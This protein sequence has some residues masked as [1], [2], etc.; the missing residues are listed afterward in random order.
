MQKPLLLTAIAFALTACGG[1]GSSALSG[2]FTDAEVANVEYE[3]SSGLRG[4]TD[5]AGRYQ[6]REGDTVT[7]RIGGLVLGSG[8]AKGTVTPID[9]VGGASSINDPEVVKILRL[10][11]S[12]DSDNN[13]ANG[14]TIAD[15]VRSAMGSSTRK[16]KDIG[17]VAALVTSA[18]PGASVV[19][20][21]NA[22]AHFAETLNR[23][24][25]KDK[26]A[27]LGG[28]S[29]F[30]IGGGGKN[31]SSFNGDTQSS[32]CAAD[33]TT[34]LANDPAFAGKTKANISFDSNYVMPTFTYSITQANRDR[35]NAVPTTLFDA[36]RKATVLTAIDGRIA[37]S[38]NKTNLSFSDFDGSKPEYANGSALW[39]SDLSN[40]DFDLLLVSM[41]ATSAPAN[42]TEC[43]LSNTNID[44]VRNGAFESAT[45]RDK[46]VV[47]LQN[48]QTVLGSGSIKYRRNSDGT[49]ASP[50]FRAEFQARTLAADGSAVAAGLTASL[51]SAEK[52]ILRSVFV[53]AN[54]QTNR[55]IEARTVK[56]LSNQASYDIY[57][58][59]VEAAKTIAGGNKPKIGVVT[60]SADNAFYD[61]DINVWA[62][63]SAGAEV[64]YLPFNGGLRRAM[65]ANDCSNIV[66]YYDAF[67]NTNAAGDALH[68]D[69][70]YP[71]YAQTQASTC[72]NASAL[73]AT[74]QSLHGIYFSGGDQ[75]RHLESLFTKSGSGNST[76]FAAS[77]E[78]NTLRNRFNAGQLVVAGTSA[79]D[80]IQ[81][82]GTWKNT[83]VPMIG[84]GDSYAALTSGFAQGTG[85]AL[86]TPAAA[87]IYTAGGHGFFKYGVLDSHFSR[88]TREARLVRATKDSGMDYGFGV[89]ENTALVVGKPATD[90]TTTMTVLGE[91]GVFVVDVRNATVTS[92]ANAPYGISG[93][94]VHY[95]VQGDRLMINAAGNLSVKLA[96]H[97]ARPVLPA[98]VN[99]A[100]IQQ[101][102]ILDYGSWN[103]LTMARSMGLSGASTAVGTNSASA[104]GRTTQTQAYTLTLTRTGESVFRG[105]T[106]RV[107][108]TN[109]S[110]A[111]APN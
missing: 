102:R 6:Y 91:A 13:P 85:A 100:P 101:N 62:F 35:F 55:K 20:E 53:D 64:V 71:D 65:D 15:A 103:F 38:G 57:T 49:T 33:W 63:R 82:G 86:E 31:C 81:G 111:I 92:A 45:N 97:A 39:N 43:M 69:Q 75:A 76:S 34:I 107:S 36:G 44:A 67:A 90:G 30:V 61:A 18:R 26:I 83:P 105:L 42:G 110:L 56:Y 104:D 51:T 25:A 12:L 2:V 98:D 109:L 48:M 32:N 72:S 84:G 41:C 24:E 79:G 54:P 89:D 73:Q 27:S 7:F 96:S 28:V 74:L 17:D 87:T 93:V 5:A 106:D 77:A 46:V 80:H 1:G 94:K 78:I 21:A 37:G 8:P 58:Q 95:L 88:R 11:Q 47:I 29:N 52:A 108:Y 50:N 40:N 10:L 68:M 19:S 22:K 99:A 3:T 16:L 66:Y 4:N 60:A 14:I 59:F 9:L 70:I 23:L